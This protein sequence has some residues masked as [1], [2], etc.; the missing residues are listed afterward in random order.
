MKSLLRSIFLTLF[1]FL[2]LSATAQEKATALALPDSLVGKL[3]ENR[4]NDDVRGKALVDII[5]YLFEHR[6]HEAAL[7]YI[8]E[9]RNLKYYNEGDYYQVALCDYYYACYLCNTNQPQEALRWVEKSFDSLENA[10]ENADTR[11]LFVRI[12]LTKGS[13]YFKLN[14]YSEEYNCL[15]EGLEVAEIDQDS[16]LLWKLHNNLG[17]M[18]QNLYRNRESFESL[19]KALKY[20]PNNFTVLFN[21]AIGHTLAKEMD[22]TYQSYDS[23]YLYMY[24][25]LNV[26]KSKEDSVSVLYRLGCMKAMDKSYEESKDYLTRALNYYEQNGALHNLCFTKRELAIIERDM[27]NLDRALEHINE[28]IQ[29]AEFGDESEV[30]AYCYGIKSEIESKLG[31]FEAAYYDAE[32]Q[33][34]AA[35]KLSQSRNE[36]KLFQSEQ[37]WF[38]IKAQEQLRYEQFK[39]KQKQRTTWIVASIL[40]FFCMVIAI[41]LISMNRKRRKMLEL[42]LNAQNREMAS[43]A[44]N[45]MHVNEVLEDI[46]NRLNQIQNTSEGTEVG[47]SSMIHDLNEMVDDGSKKDFD[48]FFVKVHPDFYANLKKDFPDLTTNDLRLCAFIK[49]KLSTKEIAELNNM[50]A[51]SVKNSRSRL[52]KKM[53]L[54]D[55][56][57]S[58]DNLI[59]KY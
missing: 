33:K 11:K 56:N 35:E 26:A 12:S 4:Q 34:K 19:L 6:Q 51:D 18:Y 57:E 10:I 22:S 44:L 53:G 7:P 13:C 2:A 21:L 52:R 47:L 30:L 38:I 41:L 32:N 45:Q 54:T 20:S 31:Y 8:K 43:K 27:G 36:E 42:K 50:S 14:L 37:N 59:S 49:A 15:Q 9:L 16:L 1:A 40:V 39:A 28:T 48:Y 25:A 5:E 46:V 24:Q 23:A 3:K 17:V 29:I 55:P 58:L